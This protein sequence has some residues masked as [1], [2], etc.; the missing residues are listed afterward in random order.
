MLMKSQLLPEISL[1]DPQD[2]RG[3]WSGIEVDA[4]NGLTKEVAGNA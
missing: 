3:G 4:L 2:V 1:G